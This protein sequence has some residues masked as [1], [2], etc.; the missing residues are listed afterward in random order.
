MSLY[1]RLLAAV[2][3][4]RRLAQEATPGPWTVN[5]GDDYHCVEHLGDGHSVAEVQPCDD[6]PGRVAPDA[7]F[8]A[9]NDPAR[10]LRA[11]D[12]DAKVLQRH[13]PKKPL[14]NWIGCIFCDDERAEA[15]PCDDARDLAEEYDVD[16]EP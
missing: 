8:I 16:G 12:R 6:H 9:A 13:A 1:E 15:W 2:A 10:I 7:T 14:G 5:E 4:R 3:E 11:C